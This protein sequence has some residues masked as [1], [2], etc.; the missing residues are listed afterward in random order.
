MSNRRQRSLQAR[1]CLAAA[2]LAVA[3]LAAP[4]VAQ[5]PSGTTATLD[6]PRVGLEP[7]RNNTAGI[8]L[9]NMELVSWSPKPMPFDSARGLTYINSDLAFRGNIVYQA[10]SAGSASGM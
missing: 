4:V 9:E 3:A 2:A 10:T 5:T 1:S 8:A 6:D 7:G